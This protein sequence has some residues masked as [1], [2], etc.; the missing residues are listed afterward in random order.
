VIP[1]GGHLLVELENLPELP[2]EPSPH[3]TPPP[4]G[5]A[6]PGPRQGSCQPFVIV[7]TRLAPVATVPPPPLA[8]GLPRGGD[9]PQREGLSRAKACA[10]LP[11]AGPSALLRPLSPSTGGPHKGLPLE[12]LRIP[13]YKPSDEAVGNL[14]QQPSNI[15]VAGYPLG[16][17][18]FPLLGNV[19]E[20]SPGSHANGDAQRSVAV[21]GAFLAAAPFLPASSVHDHE[22]SRDQAWLFEDVVDLRVQG[23]FRRWKRM[24]GRHRRFLLR[25]VCYTIL[26][27]TRQGTHSKKHTRKCLRVGRNN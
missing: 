13:L 5:Q 15:V 3:R 12:G 8:P 21:P 4:L 6:P 24:H 14:H 25:R 17:A 19:Q 10:L 7:G 9:P 22:A 11:R 27:Q 26:Y 20:P 1:K 16:D 18:I 2:Q 23:P